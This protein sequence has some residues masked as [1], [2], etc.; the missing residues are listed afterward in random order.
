MCTIFLLMIEL[1]IVKLLSASIN[2]WWKI[3]YI[4]VFGLI[5]KTFMELLISTVNASDHT[6][7]VS[8]SN[9]KCEIQPTFVNL[10]SNEYSQEFR[11]Y[12][13]TVK[14]GKYVGSCNTLNNLSN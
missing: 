3:W 6:N 14:S 9:Q 13:F 4:I 5:K 2:I 7:C 10:H 1:L 8:L 11:Y 12:P